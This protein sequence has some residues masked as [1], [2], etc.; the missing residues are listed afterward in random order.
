MSL[1]ART[2]EWNI[3]GCSHFRWH[4]CDGSP[5]ALPFLSP[6]L[7]SGTDHDGVAA[8]R[9]HRFDGT[10][11]DRCAVLFGAPGAATR[12]RRMPGS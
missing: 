5:S 10:T 9:Q 3:I 8:R 4:S 12:A 1:G 7:A 2:G 11:Y 6:A